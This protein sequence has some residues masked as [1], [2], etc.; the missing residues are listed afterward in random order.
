MSSYIINCPSPLFSLCMPFYTLKNGFSISPKY[1]VMT[2][3]DAVVGIM[4]YLP[5]K[6]LI[7]VYHWKRIRNEGLSPVEAEF[8]NDIDSIQTLY[9][10][11]EHILRQYRIKSLL[12][13]LYFFSKEISTLLYW[14]KRP[15]QS[16]LKNEVGKK[17]GV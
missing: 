14:K 1:V 5:N 8:F 10:N 13:I 11:I 4:L 2:R 15:I 16:D 17:Y 6:T 3:D 9:C 7:G 12:D